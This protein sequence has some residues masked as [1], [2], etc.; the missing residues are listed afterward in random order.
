MKNNSS[1]YLECIR[2]HRN[3]QT[4]YS[5]CTTKNI[6]QQPM[7]TLQK[8]LNILFIKATNTY[9]PFKVIIR[10]Q[11][12]QLV[13]TLYQTQRAA[14]KPKVCDSQ[15]PLKERIRQEA[16][17]WFSRSMQR[18]QHLFCH[19]CPV[20]P[21]VLSVFGPSKNFLGA[22]HLPMFTSIP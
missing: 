13:R 10:K 11:S 5:L 14:K 22:F 7:I 20:R 4:T 8:L 17:S 6:F 16:S 21:S 19:S 15:M 2:K 12:Y 3:I 18:T 9:E 1:G